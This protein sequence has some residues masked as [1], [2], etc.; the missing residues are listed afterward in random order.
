MRVILNHITNIKIHPSISPQHHQA[1][2]QA[3]TRLPSGGRHPHLLKGP[4][5]KHMVYSI[6]GQF[7]GER[8]LFKY[9][10]THQQQ[11]FFEIIGYLTDHNYESFAQKSHWK[12]HSTDETLEDYTHLKLPE[13]SDITPLVVFNDTPTSQNRFIKTLP[14]L[15]IL[16]PEQIQLQYQ[17]SQ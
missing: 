10:H 14:R 2:L 8:V 4:F 13:L 11:P 17:L 9:A 15:K 6:D 3:I 16:N 1:I 5:H 7:K 12:T